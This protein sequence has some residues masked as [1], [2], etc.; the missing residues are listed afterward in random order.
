MRTSAL[1][2][3][4][5]AGSLMA[6]GAI[7][8]SGTDSGTEANPKPAGI[9]AFTMM[10][11]NGEKKPLAEYRGKALLIVNTASKCGFT[12]QYRALQALYERFREQ[13]FVVLAFPANNFM[14]Q[15]PGT[16]Q[17]IREFCTTRYN[18]TFPLFAKVSVKGK[19]IHPLYAWLT[20]DSGY[21][22]D[23]KW[24]FNKFLV[25]ASGKVVARYDSGTDPLSMELV[26]KVMTILPPTVVA[27]AKKS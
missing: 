5:V 10:T 9:Y 12:P 23:I 25:D 1:A 8:G 21:P 6:A 24:N 20:R 3:L 19:D 27:P 13:G 18:V 7:A 11:I 22:G 17:Q 14:N 2:S 15:E 26:R 16:N 4:F